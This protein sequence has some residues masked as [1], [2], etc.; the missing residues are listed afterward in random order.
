MSPALKTAFEQIYGPPYLAR[1]L[2]AELGKPGEP[3]LFVRLDYDGSFH[4]N[5]G[6]LARNTEPFAVIAGKAHAMMMMEKFLRAQSFCE[7][8]MEEAKSVALDAWVVGHMALTDDSEELPSRE[9]IAEHRQEQLRNATVEAAL[10]DRKLRN[11]VAYRLLHAEPE[12]P[13]QVRQEALA[14]LR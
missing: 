14:E 13:K 8:P 5:G 2:F 11:S 1:L 7:S 12:E 9:K 4:T 10:L 6:P 3:D